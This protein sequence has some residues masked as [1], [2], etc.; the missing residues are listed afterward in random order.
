MPV[1]IISKKRNPKRQLRRD[2]PKH[3]GR[4]SLLIVGS[5]PGLCCLIS[6]PSPSILEGTLGYI[7]PARAR[8]RNPARQFWIGYS[9]PPDHRLTR[10]LDV[11]GDRPQL[12]DAWRHAEMPLGRKIPGV[13]ETFLLNSAHSG[14]FTST[15]PNSVVQER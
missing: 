3:L 7:G 2:S 9:G 1:S 13:S 11:F 15:C 6:P 12:S 4:F 14:I 5:W 10:V 8:P